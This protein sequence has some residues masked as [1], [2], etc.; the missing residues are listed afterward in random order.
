MA[1]AGAAGPAVEMVRLFQVQLRHYE[2]VE[3]E[4]LSL[5]GKANQLAQMVR[6][7]LPA[8]M[9]GF[10]V[11]PLFAGYDHR[12][13]RGRVFSYDATGGKYEE[14]DYMANGS[15]GVHAKNWIKAG[16][17]EGISVRRR[18]RARDPLAVRSGR[19]G[20][21]HRWPGPHP[22]HLPDGRDHRHRR[23]PPARR[24]R[25][26]RPRR[27][28]CSP[29]PNVA[30]TRAGRRD[31][32]NMPFYVS[33]EQMMKDRADYARKGIARGR[34]LVALECAAGVVIVAENPSRTLYKI[35]E[36]YDRI[37]FAGVGKYN[38][39]QSLKIGGVR[40]ADLKGYQYSPEDVNAGGLA[41]AYAQTLGQV[42]THEMKPYEVEILVASVG[43]TE[44]EPDQLFHILY[45]GTV[46]DEQGFTVLGGEADRIKDA[47]AARLRRAGAGL[48]DAVKL[49]A[50]VLAG[51]DEAL[52]PGQLEV[53]LLDRAR[54]DRAFRRIK[55]DEL[56]ALLA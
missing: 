20:R 5:E 28:T 2:K 43:A 24:R 53:A 42:F 47:L 21:R 10:V 30:A 8:A 56:E 38:E 33:P 39:F 17:S 15:G 14:A 48:A 50:K 11:V 34:S 1:I 32:M 31:E 25:R 6:A 22:G 35:S 26:R 51:D 19:R 40:L 3:G 36:I 44:D 27:R 12:R 41:N 18:G 49:G 55:G 46:M 52:T 4:Q 29:V 7:N 37:A 9:Q 45:D 54:P 13:R 16:W 23:L